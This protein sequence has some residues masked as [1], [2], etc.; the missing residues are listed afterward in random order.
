MSS[1]RDQF[2]I[3]GHRGSPERECENTIES[4]EAAL[5]DGANGLEV[6]V[7]W[8]ADGEAA[9]WH[10]E[11]PGAAIARLRQLG[12]EPVVKCRPR[13]PSDARFL[14]PVHELTLAQL[15][16]H[17][18]Y[19]AGAL[20][21]AIPAHIPTL[22]EFIQWG[23]SEAALSV[24]FLDVKVTRQ[25]LLQP[26]MRRLDELVA[27]HG[28]RFDIVLESATANVA[29]A[30]LSY[31]PRY[32]HALDVE[33]SAGIVTDAEEHSAVRA[34]IRFGLSHAAAQK[35]RSTTLFPFATHRRIIES[36]L[37]LM[38]RHNES[39]PA[40]PLRGIC[41]FTINDEDEMKQ[42][43]ELGVWGIQS[44]RPALL[45]RVAEATGQARSEPEHASR[46]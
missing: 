6:D 9:I 36:D 13:V 40:A 23:S 11:D 25:D 30:L 32:G 20:G 44:D 33:P 15:R 4:C 27:A 38:Q 26:L 18:G 5:A 28:P 24:V 8:T 41:A 37:V 1:T 29:E 42:L 43:L 34:A 10:D 45:R 16:E 22:D 19:A 2:R 3:I 46:A 31:G 17:Y 14:R 35:P 7:C 12:L 39:Q 21:D